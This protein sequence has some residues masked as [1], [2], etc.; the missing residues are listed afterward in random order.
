MTTAIYRWCATGMKMNAGIGEYVRLIDHDRELSVKVAERDQLRTVNANLLAAL[1]KIA[2][3]VSA[4]LSLAHSL[5][6]EI[7]NTNYS[8]LTLRLEE[9]RAALGA[10]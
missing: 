2:N 8:C 1:E 7:G 5:R 6:G 3:E 9:A 4:T 10:K